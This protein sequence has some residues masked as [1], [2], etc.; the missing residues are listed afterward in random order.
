MALMKDTVKLPKGVEPW[1]M[2]GLK[3]TPFYGS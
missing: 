3:G 1:R 2:G